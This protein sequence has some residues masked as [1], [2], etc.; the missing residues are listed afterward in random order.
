MIITSTVYFQIITVGA[1]PQAICARRTNPLPSLKCHFQGASR[2]KCLRASPKI[3]IAY[4]RKTTTTHLRFLNPRLANLI[5]CC[6]INQLLQAPLYLARQVA[7]M[8]SILPPRVDRLSLR[9][10][11]AVAQAQACS[12]RKLQLFDPLGENQQLQPLSFRQKVRVQVRQGVGP[13]LLYFRQNQRP[14]LQAPYLKCS[15]QPLP[16]RVLYLGAHC[17]PL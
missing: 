17:F 4:F 1:T 10:R 14:Q 2:L 8:G 16:P 7:P 6:S 15:Q 12:L 9:K 13:C 11:K 5:A 3:I